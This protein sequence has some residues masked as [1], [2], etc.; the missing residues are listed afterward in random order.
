MPT[1]RFNQEVLRRE[2]HQGGEGSRVGPFGS[3]PAPLLVVSLDYGKT[4]RWKG[5][6]P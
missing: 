3:S 5:Q 6:E 4:M 2:M 1:T